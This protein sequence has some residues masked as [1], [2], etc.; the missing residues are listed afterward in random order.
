[1][2]GTEQSLVKAFIARIT[3]TEEVVTGVNSC[4][5]GNQTEM[6]Y[7]QKLSLVWQEF[8]VNVKLWQEYLSFSFTGLS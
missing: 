3:S 2:T 8:P 5:T 6:I 1:M 7:F 4:V